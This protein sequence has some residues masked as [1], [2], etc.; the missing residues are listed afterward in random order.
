MA[1]KGLGYLQFNPT[2]FSTPYFRG[3]MA[4]RRMK[5]FVTCGYPVNPFFS[6][7]SDFGDLEFDPLYHG[8][9]YGGVVHHPFQGD[10]DCTFIQDFNPAGPGNRLRF[11]MD[12]GLGTMIE[13]HWLTDPEFWFWSDAGFTQEYV[14]DF[15]SGGFSGPLFVQTRP[16][17]Y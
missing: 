13:G 10:F 16:E 12:Q 8:L 15:S 17:P 4:P 14:V 2:S 3:H 5:V 11:R 1:H 7:P 9:V 6:Y